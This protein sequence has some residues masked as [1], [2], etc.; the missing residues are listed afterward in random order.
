MPYR[1]NHR[2]LLVTLNPAQL[3]GCIAL[4]LWLGFLAIALTTWLGYKLFFNAPLPITT[5]AP[6]PPAM[7]TPEGESPMFEQYQNNLRRQ[8]QSQGDAQNHNQ[9][10]KCQFWLQQ[11]R[12]APTDKSRTNVL[13]FCN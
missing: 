3:V 1:P 6:P 2:Q 5:P 9:D 4:G 10:P 13:K 8:E 12:T 7:N 11:D